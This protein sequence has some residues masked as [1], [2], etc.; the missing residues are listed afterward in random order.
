MFGKTIKAEYNYILAVKDF[1]NTMEAMKTGTFKTPFNRE[2]YMKL[3]ENHKVKANDVKELKNLIK[4]S[5]KQKKDVLHFWE[6]LL[7]R[8]YTLFGVQYDH[9]VPSFERLCDNDRIK[10]VCAV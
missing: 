3:I 10:Y 7:V 1:T 5:N 2:I 9:E 8:G 6:G 4:S